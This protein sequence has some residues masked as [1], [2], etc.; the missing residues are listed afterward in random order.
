MSEFNEEDIKLIYT[1]FNTMLDSCYRCQSD[2]NRAEITK[3]FEF[4]NNAHKGMRRKSN[5]P[6]II[7]PIEV[8]QIAGN[9]IG[10]ETVAVVSAL[11]HDVVE[12]THYRTEDIQNLFGKKVAYIVDGLTK[13]ND[14]FEYSA[15]LQQ[16]IK[17]DLNKVNPNEY[18]VSIQAENFR[19]IL[20]T[21]S[22]DIRVVLIKLADRLHNMRTLESMP[23]KSQL[24]S[25][26]ETFY[27]YAPLAHRLG[28]YSIKTELENLS[29]KYHNP[30]LYEELKSRIAMDE[31]RRSH[32]VNKFALPIQNKLIDENIDCNISGRP[33]SIYSIAK[34]MEQKHVLY[35]EIFDLLAIRIVFKPKSDIPESL[36][37][38]HIYEIVTSIYLPKPDRLRDWLNIPKPNGYTALHVTVMGHEGKFFEVQIRSERMNEIAE[39]G[40]AAHWQYKGMVENTSTTH[41]YNSQFETFINQ[42]R[43]ILGSP[44]TNALDFLDNF[45]SDIF[46][47]EIL[48]FTPKG[49]IV[50]LP[51]NSTALDFAFAIHT[52]I[53]HAAIAAK[54]NYKLVGLNHVLSSGDQVEIIKSDK[55]APRFEWLD[56]VVTA[57]AKTKLSQYFKKERKELVLE[58]ATM[59]SNRLKE[60]N[61]ILSVKIID[62]MLQTYNINE[63]NQLLYEIATRQISLDNIKDFIETKSDGKFINYWKI[64]SLIGVSKR[65]TEF[66]ANNSDTKKVITLNENF[67]IEK[68]NFSSCCNPIPGDDVVGYKN[69]STEI[70]VI[71]KT[72]CYNSI[73]LNSSQNKNVVKVEWHTHKLKSFLTKVVLQ[74]IDRQ[75]LVNNITDMLSRDLK[76]NMKSIYFDT[77]EGIFDG[78]IEVY[79]HDTRDLNNL[80]EKLK[81][82]K[83]VQSVNRLERMN[84]NESAEY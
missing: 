46:S 15:S 67:D 9:E 3:A 23:R 75:G 36:Q 41:Q 2:E 19:K 73:K 57:R 13:I 6:F 77:N 68:Y 4:A 8:A 70:I 44:E 17:P 29:F 10:L 83:N 12:D 16:I 49:R 58:G 40:I 37:C 42:V 74:G 61:T 25:A 33:K 18:G 50:H 71:H 60:H 66:E 55:S 34:K 51:V 27:L 21:I 47:P 30:E 72:S 45:R 1:K 48:T 28:L 81:K 54:V 79:V 62:K 26:A 63:K 69:T 31:K 65:K 32:M 35:D 14:V 22:E 59:L 64:G 11:L 24:R 7:H 38:W 56:F 43:D 53:A 52:E 39:R 76:V 5:E 20:F 84:T 82:I 80:I 78:T